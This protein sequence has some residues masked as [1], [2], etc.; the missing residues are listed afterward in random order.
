[1]R[2]IYI[3]D[4]GKEFED[5]FECEYYEWALN[6]PHLKSIKF[7]DKDGNELKDIMKEDTYDC[8]CKIMVPTREAVKEINDL[9]DYTG[10]YD[11][12]YITEAGTWIYEKN[13]TGRRFVK[14]FD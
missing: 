4:D 9:A 12:S 5:Q 11:Y 2:I 7:Y 13:S 14:C 3:A 6:H 1:M 10:Y 8:C